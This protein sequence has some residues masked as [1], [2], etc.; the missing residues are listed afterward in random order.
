V[1]RFESCRGHAQAT[2]AT[3]DAGVS[4]VQGLGAPS[5]RTPPR[6]D[7]N[8]R[9]H[10]DRGA[11]TVLL[12]LAL[13]IQI[14]LGLAAL[15]VGGFEGDVVFAPLIGA[16]AVATGVV[17]LLLVMVRRRRWRPATAWASLGA[18]AVTLAAF[19]L[20]T[21]PLLDMQACTGA[22]RAA[23]LTVTP[24]GERPVDVHGGQYGCGYSVELTERVEPVVRYYRDGFERAGWTVTEQPEGAG[25]TEG[26]GTL[27]VG[28]L[29]ATGG[30]QTV[31][32]VYEGAGDGSYASVSVTAT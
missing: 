6:P 28:E 14:F 30:G 26:G 21:G 20:A 5:D 31:S 8:P 9:S 11:A 23:V 17:V 1:R 4:L 25:Q 29:T 24:Y 22:R 12:L 3:L 2:S 32:I 16:W 18:V 10:R 19:P 13:A 15:F 7:L 27:S